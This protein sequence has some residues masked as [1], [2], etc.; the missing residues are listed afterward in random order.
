MIITAAQLKAHLGIISTEEDSLI[1]GY[2]AQIGDYLRRK[3]GRIIEEE[4]VTEYHD[5]DNIKD[6]IFLANYPVSELTS[7][8]YR[9]G[10]FANPTWNDYPA[11]DYLLSEDDGTIQMNF[12]FSGLKN[13]KVVYKAGWAD[14]SIPE[15]LQLAAIK[16]VAK[17]YNKRRSDGF[18]SEEVAGARVDWDTFLSKDIEELINPF[19]KFKI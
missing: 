16:L 9:S 19:R 11:E 13:I 4:S 15:S 5:G 1:T 17:V 12:V 10:G 18:S 3:I 7:I 14:G 8:Q 2:I 6:M